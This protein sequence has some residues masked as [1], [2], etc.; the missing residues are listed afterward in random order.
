MVTELSSRRNWRRLGIIVALLCLPPG[1]LAAERAPTEYEVKA[2][3]LFNFAKFVTWPP[4]SFPAAESPVLIG[5]LG[6]DPFGAA[7]ERLAAE[8]RVQGRP[9]RVVRGTTVAELVRCHVLFIS[10]S[11]R[12]RMGQ[13]LQG[14]RQAGSAALTVGETDGF[15]GAGGIIRFL[16]EQNKVRFEISAEAAARARLAISSKLLSLGVNTR[17]RS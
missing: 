5:V 14:L 13:I 3:F 15:L 16:V 2:A 9:L 12:D 7:L 1:I 17:P 10:A 6:A 4:E 11:E 8:L